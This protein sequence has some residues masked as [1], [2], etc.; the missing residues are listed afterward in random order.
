MAKTGIKKYDVLP[1]RL[2]FADI[3]ATRA[4]YNHI[5]WIRKMINKGL[6]KLQALNIKAL[7]SAVKEHKKNRSDKK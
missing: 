4:G 7:E 1:S 5:E 3:D 6:D 2:H